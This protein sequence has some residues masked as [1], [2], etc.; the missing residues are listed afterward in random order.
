MKP[1]LA[2]TVQYIASPPDQPH[3]WRL[4]SHL[5]GFPEIEGNHGGEN[6]AAVVLGVF[7]EYKIQ[8]KVLIYDF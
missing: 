8:S 6:L 3:I 7:N 2:I 4:K 5:I 1:F